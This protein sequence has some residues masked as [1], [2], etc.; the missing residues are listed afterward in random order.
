MVPAS[1]TVKFKN[2]NLPTRAQG[3]QQPCQALNGKLH[4]TLPL[5]LIITRQLLAA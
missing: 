1:A 2:M 5:Q 3:R 4:F